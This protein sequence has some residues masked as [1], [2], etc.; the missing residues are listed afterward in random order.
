MNYIL[1][2]MAA[3]LLL[4]AGCSTKRNTFLSR[5]FHNLTS[6]YNVYWNGNE[7]L[8][9]ADYL[10]QGQSVDN[11]FNVI[12]VFKYGNPEDTA[13]IAQQ[14]QRM[15][16]KALLTI[17]KHSISIRGKEYVKTIDNAYILLGKGFF[18]KQDYSKARSVFNFVLSEYPTCGKKNTGWHLPS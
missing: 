6:Y 2:C 17:K 3:S 9:D 7:T 10:L 13:L 11:Y 15:I 18:Y 5:N 12:P 1:P 4:L 16:E 14:T 8:L